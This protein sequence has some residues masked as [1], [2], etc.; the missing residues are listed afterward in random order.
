MPADNVRMFRPRQSTPSL[1]GRVFSVVFPLGVG[2]LLFNTPLDSQ[3]LTLFF[4]LGLV[5]WVFIRRHAIETSLFTRSHF[6][7]TTMG[8][9]L[10][11]IVSFLVLMVASFLLATAGLTGASSLAPMLS[12]GVGFVRLAYHYGVALYV[13]AQAIQGLLGR[14]P[15][16]P[17]VTRNVDAWA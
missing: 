12:E 7:H 8:L 9:L 2:W 14:T 13:G 5:Y 16:F 17:I 15:N 4:M 1:G 11:Y 10:L 3:G 6:L